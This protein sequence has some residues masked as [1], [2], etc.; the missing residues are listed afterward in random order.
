[1]RI[2][3]LQKATGIGGSERHLLMLLPG[4]ARAGVEVRMAVAVAGDGERFAAEMRER[5]VETHTVAAGPDVNPRLVAWTRRQIRDYKPDLLHT[6]LIHADL[7]GQL[8]ARLAR[9]PAVSSVHGTPAFLRRGP[10]AVAGRAVGRMPRLTIAI[11]EHVKRFL[12][13]GGLR[14]RG[15]VRVVYYGLDA[16]GW[17]PTAEGRAEARARFGLAPGDVALAMTARLIPGKG[18]EALIDAAAEAGRRVPELRLV[19]AG[20]GPLRADLERLAAE[21]LPEGAARFIGFVDDV[22]PVVW[23]ADALVFPTTPELSEGFGLAALEAMAAE[24]PVVATEVG[25]LPEVVADRETGLVVPPG[26][27]HALAEALVELAGQ[28]ELRAAMG[29]SGLRRATSLFGVET[30]VDRT[31]SVYRDALSG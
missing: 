3:H 30:M 5:G 29:Q 12:E 14:R 26:D 18:H 20:D 17:A 19:I 16:G 31:V 24:R 13:S 2:L 4:L 25:A 8:A 11:S 7:H 27:T 22:R 23:A 1:M 15:T 10:V 21:R 9:I 6:H 28:P